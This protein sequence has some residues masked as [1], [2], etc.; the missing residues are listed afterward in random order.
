MAALIVHRPSPESDTRPANCERAGSFDQGGRRQI[1]QPR[2][3][4]AAAPPHLGD[5]PQIEVVLVVLGVAQ[6]RR[7]GVDRVLLLADVGVAQDAQPL[8]IGRHE[9]VLDAVV[10]HLDE[11]AGAGRP[12]V[13]IALFGGAAELLASR[14]ARNVAHAGRQRR[15]DRIEMLNHLL[16]PPIIMQ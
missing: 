13:Q 10:D 14:R 1:Q 3:D 4:H 6:R 15:E 12:A 11:V 7:L 2:R 8:G 16:A 5:V 9:A